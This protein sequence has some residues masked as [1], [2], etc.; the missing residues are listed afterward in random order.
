MN[1]KEAKGVGYVLSS[2]YRAKVMRTLEDGQ[3]KT[4]TQIAKDCEIRPNHISNVLRQLKDNNLVVC[5]NE[6]VRKGR[7]YTLTKFGVKVMN[8]IDER[9]FINGNM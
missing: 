2:G 9:G 4:P 1:T 6:E 5:I 3:Y 7:I 8:H